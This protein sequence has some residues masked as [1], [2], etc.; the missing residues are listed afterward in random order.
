MDFVGCCETANIAFCKNRRLDLNEAL[1]VGLRYAELCRRFVRN[2]LLLGYICACARFC[3]L[4]CH[5]EHCGGLAVFANDVFE[6][7]AKNE[8]EIIDAIKAQRH[9][10]DGRLVV[11]PEADPIYLRKRK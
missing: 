5:V 6:F 2:A 9:T 7:M 8:P 10:D 1:Q 3:S 11:Q 4:K